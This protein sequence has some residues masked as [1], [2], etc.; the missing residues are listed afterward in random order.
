MARQVAHAEAIID[1]K[2][3]GVE[4]GKAKL[5][6]LI[7]A[8]KQAEKDGVI[9]YKINLDKSGAL[10]LQKLQ[11]E[12]NKGGKDNLKFSIDESVF[13]KFSEYTGDAKTEAEQLLSIFQQL[14]KAGGFGQ[15]AEEF[16]AFKAQLKEQQDL[17]QQ[18]TKVV[19]EYQN[20]LDK[21]RGGNL[22]K[23]NK[24]ISELEQKKSKSGENYFKATNKQESYA[25]D[26]LLESYNEYLKDTKSSKNRASFYNAAQ[27]FD[28]LSEDMYL[29]E[30]EH[31]KVFSKLR[32]FGDKNNKIQKS[33]Y[34]I[35][36]EFYQMDLD[37]KKGFSDKDLESAQKAWQ[38][39]QKDIDADVNKYSAEMED[40]RKKISALEVKKSKIE[41]SKDGKNAEQIQNVQ[42]L[43]NQ[44]E[45]AKKETEAK[46]QELKNTIRDLQSASEQVQ[47]ETEVKKSETSSGSNGTSHK[48]SENP[49]P[50]KPKNLNGD[51]VPETDPDGYHP[52]KIKVANMEEFTQQIEGKEY[53]IKVKTD[54][55]ENIANDV[56]NQLGESISETVKEASE[57]KKL[58]SAEVS[59]N[60]TSL[61]QKLSD[62]K[63]KYLDSNSDI[64]LLKENY[65]GKLPYRIDKIT[66]EAKLSGIQSKVKNLQ[67]A[68]NDNNIEEISKITDE[69]VASMSTYKNFEDILTQKT[70]TKDQK[71]FI[72]STDLKARVEKAKADNQS[73][74]DEMNSIVSEIGSL[75]NSLDGKEFTKDNAKELMAKLKSGSLEESAKY[76][77][78]SF[79]LD[80]SS[81][82]QRLKK[83]VESTP[84]NLKVQFNDLQKQLKDLSRGELASKASEIYQNAAKNG[85]LSDEDKFNLLGLGEAFRNKNL[86]DWTNNKSKTGRDDRSIDLN[87]S[88]FEKAI[89]QA[90]MD[91]KEV[92]SSLKSYAKETGLNFTDNARKTK[93]QELSQYDG[94]E[95]EIF[96][97]INSIG[98]EYMKK[99]SDSIMSEIK[100]LLKS[101]VDSGKSLTED[102]NK[103]LLAMTNIYKRKTG[104]SARVSDILKDEFGITDFDKVLK[105]RDILKSVYDKQLKIE[106]EKLRNQEDT[107]Q[108]EKKVD[109]QKKTIKTKQVQ[110]KEI[111]S[112]TT[113]LKKKEKENELPE[114]P[115]VD[116]DVNLNLNKEDITS[117][118][119]QIESGINPIEV[120]V[121][122]GDKDTESA[123]KNSSSAKDVDASYSKIVTSLQKIYELKQQIA[124]VGKDSSVIAIDEKD[125]TS[126]GNTKVGALKKL[127]N[128]YDRKIAENRRANN[129]EDNG[130]TSLENKITAYASK[131]KNKGQLKSI[132]GDERSNLWNKLKSSIMENEA[133]NDL[134]KEV[135]S[136]ISEVQNVIGRTLN[137]AESSQLKASLV[138]GEQ[139][140]LN[141][142]IGSNGDKDKSDS[143]KVIN[144]DINVSDSSIVEAKSKIEEGLQDVKVGIQ[145]ES[146]SLQAADEEISKLYDKVADQQQKVLKDNKDISL[147]PENYT[148]DAYNKRNFKKG[149]TEVSANKINN[150]LKEYGGAAAANNAAEVARLKDNLV[151]MAST[152]QNLDD[153]ATV[154]GQNQA[155]LWAEVKQRI[156]EAR[157]AQELI[158][159][160]QSQQTEQTGNGQEKVPE[161]ITI[162]TK[163]TPSVEEIKSEVSSVFAKP[164]DVKLETKPSIESI[165]DDLNSIKDKEVTVDV[166]N[167]QDESKKISSLNKR[168]KNI[169]EIDMSG[170][171]E[172]FTKAADV[173]ESQS[174]R[175]TSA[176]NNVQKSA[177]KLK[178]TLKN[179]GINKVIDV[180]KYT[181][182]VQN[183]KKEAEKAIKSIQDQQKKSQEA[184]KEQQK[185]LQNSLKNQQ[186]ESSKKT[187]DDSNKKQ[188]Q[189]DQKIVK[190]NTVND[191]KNTIS[192]YEKQYSE[193]KKFASSDHSLLNEFEV[194]AKKTVL[195]RNANDLNSAALSKIN[196]ARKNNI[197]SEQEELSFVE[198]LTAAKEKEVKVLS[199]EDFKSAQSKQVNKAKN[200][201]DELFGDLNKE[202]ISKRFLDIESKFGDTT[203]NVKDKI[204]ELKEEAKSLLQSLTS[205]TFEDKDAFSKVKDKLDTVFEQM[206]KINGDDKFKLNNFLGRNNLGETSLKDLS[207][208]EK[209]NMIYESLVSK[210]GTK[211][212][213]VGGY[214]DGLGS[215]VKYVDESGNIMKATVSID[216]YTQA[217]E[218][219]TNA[220]KENANA[221][222]EMSS[223]VSKENVAIMRMNKVSDTGK[224]YQ[225]AGD[226]WLSGLKSKIG[227]LTQ[228]V[229]GIDIVMRAW[230]EIQQGFSFVKEFD[231]ALTTINQTMNAT[232]EQLSA[233]GQGSIEAGKQL[234]ATAEDVLDAAAIYANA[235]ETTESVL[236]K[237][238]PTVLLANASGADTSTAADQIQGVV[239]QFED[240]EGQETRIVN[241]Y[242]KI[243]ASLGIDFAKGINIMS[244][245]VQTAGS[246]A[247]SAG[248]KF[249]TFAASVGK[250]SEKTRQEG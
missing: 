235:N 123:I 68:T 208:L 135:N 74:N 148:G 198:K 199:Q 55:L 27:Q 167:S 103:D 46:I 221:S 49:E 79:K 72:D 160:E 87:T 239:N 60:A 15:S 202:T 249:E 190:K 184:I 127:L 76:L 179:M 2:V 12:I 33:L 150:T 75:I 129:A 185:K 165:K 211:G 224:T 210:Y 115:K 16:N 5:E 193:Y 164:I 223:E 20:Q 85:R 207:A 212:T 23:I 225:S 248:M 196:E 191:I 176:I 188:N 50:N 175:M 110:P 205:D 78:D 47:Q 81:I 37:N 137:K 116:V 43:L 227:N 19:Q 9:T 125:L 140:L 204:I 3:N 151:A 218:K 241:S 154:F 106:A 102:Q 53:N 4:E 56:G 83:E 40:S 171:T 141:K 156:E 144:V 209:R 157:T 145:V 104:S 105:N 66:N 246:V 220:K 77:Q 42:H 62:T 7:N 162:K 245:G 94:R 119:S 100:A 109:V 173:I 86:E 189:E 197:I 214:V 91:I 41:A 88:L 230:N 108:E 111:V 45:Q 57:E 203:A 96:D 192:D 18:Q 215:K 73:M 64:G 101:S 52:I 11:N 82:T 166:N 21:L 195:E 186:K 63:K 247:E 201:Y 134:A 152:Y 99:D 114:N 243:S 155:N 142:Y 200:K 146:T 118:K 170:S 80:L 181:K 90:G 107:V 128:E 31:E 6:Q 153:V 89:E 213:K 131:Y 65:N 29:D 113:P 158:Q 182:D 174:N 236:K 70:L 168:L 120:K 22:D 10:K 187:N 222:D 147:L 39:K 216:E 67:K 139:D 95:K 48:K 1:L 250:I 229:T 132:F 228:Y 136:V 59:K 17:L 112:P 194:Y 149:T 36:D 14:S 217:I 177:N 133:P 178:S 84:I 163:L 24:Q 13:K 172:S 233:L 238:K 234:G 8:K 240:L 35:I 219:N 126:D 130:L 97:Y 92:A 71:K 34:D 232:Q 180:D 206:E 28:N 58:T 61:L 117:I 242:E 231:S 51:E 122:Y 169:S 30:D 161:E 44:A 237:A 183:A 98:K 26:A 32:S 38:Q 54:G 69:L 25:Q 143:N 93:K 159:K 244:E 138:K 226:K 124:S 121:K